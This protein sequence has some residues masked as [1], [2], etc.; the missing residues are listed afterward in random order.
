MREVVLS[1]V[2]ELLK[3][4]Q[5]A[6]INVANPNCPAVIRHRNPVLNP[7][8]VDGYEYLITV[9]W[10]YA[11]EGTGA[12]PD[13]ETSQEL[14]R[15]ET[16][17]SAAVQRDAQAIL[18]AVVTLDGA[19]QWVYYTRNVEEF[20]RR[21][22]SIPDYYGQPYPIEVTTEEDSTWSYLREEV[23]RGAL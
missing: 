3:N 23:L 6:L 7:A 22:S 8:H 5:W 4:D 10:G 17:L 15:F 13:G 11:A 2:E 9:L 14:E 19:R 16:H 1:P 18:T 21:L 20:G 12:M